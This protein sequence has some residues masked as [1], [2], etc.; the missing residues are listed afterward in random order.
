MATPN[1]ASF[2]PPTDGTPP[3]GALDAIRQRH[4]I[5]RTLGT[6]DN[7][8]SGMDWKAA[9]QAVEAFQECNADIDWLI[10]ALAQATSDAASAE[11]R[12]AALVEATDHQ[13]HEIDLLR[14]AHKEQKRMFDEWRTDNGFPPVDAWYMGP[15]ADAPDGER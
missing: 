4:Q 14:D 13:Q 12:Y 11:D 7:P 15:D 1:L 8:L 3:P 9:Q 2:E 5:R 10:D 6:A